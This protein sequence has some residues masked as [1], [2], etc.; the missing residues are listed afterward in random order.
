MDLRMTGYAVGAPQ[1]AARP[2]TIGIR[3]K[4]GA[5]GDV[6]GNAPSRASLFDTQTQVLL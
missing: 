2:V 1:T 3:P 5:T 4:Y 6:M